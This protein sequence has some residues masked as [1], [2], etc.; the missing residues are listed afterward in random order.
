[1]LSD[2]AISPAID[3][4]VKMFF[5]NFYL[6]HI[7]SKEPVCNNYRCSGYS[8]VK[9]MKN[10]SRDMIYCIRT[11]TEIERICIG[12]KRLAPVRFHLFHYLSNIDRTDIPVISPLTKMEFNCSS[13]T[14]CNNIR[15]PGAVKEPL[16]FYRCAL[17]IGIRP[18]TCKIDRTF[19]SN[20]LWSKEDIYGGYVKSIVQ[21]S[22]KEIK[23]TGFFP[24]LTLLD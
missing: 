16:Y 7:L 6:S 2:R 23:G 1:M 22:G 11:A 15:K 9:P 12:Q 21:R 18:Q 19:H 13:V 5:F 4:S 24:V 20:I 3:N 10:C 8:I 17:L 14:L